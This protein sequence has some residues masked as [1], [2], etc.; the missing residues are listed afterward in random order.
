MCV[1]MCWAERKCRSNSNTISVLLCEYLTRKNRDV[2]TCTLSVKVARVSRGAISH[3][4][5]ESLT[6]NPPS[7]LGVTSPG[8]H[9]PY[10]LVQT[11][12]QQDRLIWPSWVHVPHRFKARYL[13]LSGSLKI[14]EGH[15]FVDPEHGHASHNKGYSDNLNVSF[16]YRSE[17]FVQFRAQI[18]GRVQKQINGR[19]RF[20]HNVSS[21][22]GIC[23]LTM[24][25][26]KRTG[27]E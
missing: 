18:S 10:A 27:R 1:W 2:I 14:K 9:G 5:Y 22:I 11:P 21:C 23:K 12:K 24:G 20:T 25:K 13:A 19:N 7:S 15:H 4:V 17:C 26:V 6:I 3:P 8:E 16:T